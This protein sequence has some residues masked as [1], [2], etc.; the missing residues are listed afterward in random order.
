ET[1]LERPYALTGFEDME[2]STQILLFDAI[3]Q[4]LEISILDR[5]DQFISLKYGD[6]LEYV[7]NGNMTALDSYISPLIME[8]K[9]VTKKI[10][11]KHGFSV[12]ASMEYTNQEQA[13]RDYQ[14]FANKA[15]VVKPKSTNYGLGISIFKEGANL[16]N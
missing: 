4:G 6:H 8:N 3:Q 14:L 1:S 16:A 13:V 7:K 10:L 9:V 5:S 2:L 12:P 15:F 11:A